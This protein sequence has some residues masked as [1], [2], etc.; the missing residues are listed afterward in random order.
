MRRKLLIIN[1][2]HIKKSFATTNKRYR[3]ETNQGA[4]CNNNNN[5]NGDHNNGNEAGLA[6]STKC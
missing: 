4:I 2:R 1:P 3:R 5:G 6:L